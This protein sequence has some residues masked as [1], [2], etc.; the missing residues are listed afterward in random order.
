VS[1]RIGEHVDPPKDDARDRL[2]LL[3]ES[4]LEDEESSAGPVCSGPRIR[5]EPFSLKF[6]LPRD[7]P[8]YTRAMKLEDWLLDYGSAVDIVGGNKG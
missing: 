6:A 8:K 2:N 7:M 3:A 1:L 5:S 4:K